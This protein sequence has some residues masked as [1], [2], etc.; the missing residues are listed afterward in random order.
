MHAVL[1]RIFLAVAV[2]STIAFVYS[3]YNYLAA[4]FQDVRVVNIE[5]KLFEIGKALF[6]QD[7]AIVYGVST[8]SNSICAV[9]LS[10]SNVTLNVSG[11]F[12][13]WRAPRSALAIKGLEIY[14]K[15][16]IAAS[17]SKSDFL[18][19]YNQNGT[20]YAAPKVFLEYSANASGLGGHKVHW[21]KATSCVFAGLNVSGTFDLLKTGGGSYCRKF[22]RP[23]LFDTVVEV[24]FENGLIFSFQ[25]KRGE[26]FVFEGCVSVSEISY[27]KR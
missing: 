20:L 7:D 4:D 24:S 14:Y 21:V 12:I 5:T 9:D 6:S 25:V 22:E 23:C 10:Y 16:D 18:Q 19:L 1:S 13:V 2:I 8:G 26:I 11:D 15:P 3:G 17:I 27:Q